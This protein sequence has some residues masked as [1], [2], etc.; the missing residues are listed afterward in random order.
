MCC[1][2]I[3]GVFFRKDEV[4]AFFYIVCK[5]IFICVEWVMKFVKYEF[6]NVKID[7]YEYNDFESKEVRGDDYRAE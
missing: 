4:M 7:N 2:V 5:D 3:D 1:R 6:N